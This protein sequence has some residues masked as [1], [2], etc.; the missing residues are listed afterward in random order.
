MSKRKMDVPESAKKKQSS[1][2][3]NFSEDE[4]DSRG[5]PLRESRSVEKEYHR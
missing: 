1:C 4:E 3:A 5:S 2:D